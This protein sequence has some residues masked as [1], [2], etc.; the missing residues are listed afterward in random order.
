M[1]ETEAAKALRSYLERI[2]R[3]TEERKAIAADIGDI[4]KELESNGYDKHAAKIVLKIRAADDGMAQYTDRTATVDTYLAA[5]GMLP[6]RA[7]APARVENI[8]KFTQKTG[9]KQHGNGGQYVGRKDREQ[10]DEA[11]VSGS[12]GRREGVDEGAEGQGSGTA[13]PDRVGGPVAG[14]VAG[15][16]EDRGSRHVGGEARH[17]VIPQS[18]APTSSPAETKA[19]GTTPLVPVATPFKLRPK[20][21]NPDRCG[22]YGTKHCFDCLKADASATLQHGA[23]A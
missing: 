21:L 19:T 7:P 20:C 9:E 11:R 6:D 10:R 3:L 22:G 16:D 4:F 23:L 15:E 8:V 2:E 12:D 14:T 5:L 17:E 18:S 13:G 1:S